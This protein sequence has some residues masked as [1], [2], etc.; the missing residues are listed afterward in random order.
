MLTKVTKAAHLATQR[1]GVRQEAM[2]DPRAGV[3]APQERGAGSKLERGGCSI[4]AVGFRRGPCQ[5]AS[6]EHSAGNLLNS[7]RPS[8]P[9]QLGGSTAGEAAVWWGQIPPADCCSPENGQASALYISLNE[10]EGP[11]HRN[12]K[13]PGDADTRGPQTRSPHGRWQLILHLKAT[14][15]AHLGPKAPSHQTQATSVF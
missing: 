11:A 10:T 9:H 2:R 4:Y 6:L 15:S 13:A 3:T 1:P 12:F 8:K 14:Q 7:N 5:H